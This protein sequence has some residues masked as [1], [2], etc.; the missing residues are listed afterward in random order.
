MRWSRAAV[1]VLVVL[2]GA[3][4]LAEPAATVAH[5]GDEAYVRVYASAG[6]LDAVPGLAARVVEAYDGFALLRLPRDDLALLR[7]RGFLAVPED[8]VFR[9]GLDGWTFD[10]RRG[11]PAVPADLRAPPAAS[12]DV[13]YFLVQFR[14][15][16]KAAWLAAVEARGVEVQRYVPH[17]AYLVRGTAAAVED[18][19][20]LPF[21]SWTGAYHPAYKLRPALARADGVV[22]AKVLLFPDESVKPLLALLAA[23]GLGKT[24]SWTGDDLG[25]LRITP[26]ADGTVAKVRV[27]AS[28]LRDVARLSGVEYVEPL[29]R[30][31]LANAEMQWVLQTNVPDLRRVWDMG[32][33]GRGQVVAVGDT[34]V[35]YDHNF[36]RESATVVQIGYP[37]TSSD[38]A[39]SIYNATDPARRKLIRYFPMSAVAAGVDPFD[40]TDPWAILDSPFAPAACTSGHGTLV[41]SVG[42]GNDDWRGAASSANDGIAKDA[43]LFLQ[44]IGSVV[45]SPE[46][47]LVGG[48]TDVLVY[49]PDDLADYFIIPYADP[50]AGARIHSNSWG[51]DS[52]AYT[53]EARTVDAFVWERPDFLVLFAN[54]NR[55]PGEGT[56][57]SPATSKS[58]VSV[59]WGQP[60]PNQESVDG[61]SSKGPTADGRLKP[62]IVAVGQGVSGRSDGRID[63]FSD[64][65]DDEVTWQGT[66]YATP[67]AA[68]VAA[69]LRQYFVE[70]WYPTGTPTPANGFVPSAALLKAALLAAGRQMTGTNARSSVDTWPNVAQG[71][72]RLTADDALYFLGDAGKLFVADETAGLT[73]GETLTYEIRVRQG[74]PL[75]VLLAWSDYPATVGAN[76]AL[77][78]DLDLLL[79][80]PSGATYKGNVFGTFAQGESLANVGVFD[81]RNPVE[82]VIVADPEPGVW[83][84]RVTAGNVPQGPQPF[85]LVAVGDRDL[86][87]GVVRLDRTVYGENATIGLRVEDVDALGVT[88]RVS[89]TTETAAELVPLTRAGGRGVWTG[90]IPTGVGVP[91]LDGV[92]QVRSGDE[93]VVGYVD[94]NPTRVASA[95][96]KVDFEGPTIANVRVTA[97]G[98]TSAVVRWTTDRPASS[99]VSFGTTTALGN[100]TTE[101]ELVTDHA[102]LLSGLS[103]DSLYYFDVAST[104]RSGR[105]VRD[106]RAG[107]HYTF[108]TASQGAVLLVV[109]DDSFPEERVGMYRAALAARGWTHDEWFVAA[110]GDP[111]LTTLR[112]YQAVLWQVGLEQYPPF[113]DPQIALLREYVD[114]GGRLFVSS[115][116]VAW[117]FCDT[118]SP[119]FSTARCG[120]LRGTLKATWQADPPSWSQ[121]VGYAG[122][123]ISG[124]YTGGVAYTPHRTGGA[125]DEIDPVAAGGTTNVTWRNTDGSPD[126]VAV[127]WIASAANVTPDGGLWNGTPSRVVSFFFEFTGIDFANRPD[128]AVRADILDRVLVFLSGRDKPQV[129]VLAPNG[130]EVETGDVVNVT[131]TVTAFGANVSSQS[132]YYSP[133]GGQTW[134]LLND[135]LGPAATSYPWNV[136]GVENGDAYLVRVVVADDG[137]PPFRGADRSNGTFALRRPG[138]DGRGPLVVPGSLRLTPTPTRNGD[139][140]SLEALVSDRGRGDGDVNGTI[141]AEFFVDAVAANGSGVP[142]ALASPAGPE[143]AVAWSDTLPLAPGWHTLYVHGQ[144]EDGNWGPFAALP[145]LALGDVGPPP[146]PPGNVSARLEGPG[147]KDVRVSWTA[148]PDDGAL[149]GYEILVAPTYNGSRLGYSPLATVPRGTTSYVHVDAGEGD[150]NAYFYVVVAVNGSGSAAPFDQAAKVVLPVAA[151]RQLL[152]LPVVPEDGSV[153]AVFAS[154][155]VAWI[156]RYDPS[157]PV[158]PWKA[159]VRAKG[160]GSLA[161]IPYA[162][163]LWVEVA[164]A[165][166]L[167]VAGRIPL[168][169]NLSLLPGWNLLA[170]PAFGGEVT[171]GDWYAMGMARLEGYD[172][173]A[174]PYYLGRLPEGRRLRVGEGFWVFSPRSLVVAVAA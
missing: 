119:F 63:V 117:A 12:D 39:T 158:D 148:S 15:P 91:R 132:L 139:V 80:A 85:A 78:N 53:F 14:G 122:D 43:K 101:D 89:S 79:T 100:A 104:G 129:D 167:V 11:E 135:T 169:A 69:L 156:R 112:A 50:N 66:S 125:G 72:G 131:W 161:T 56:V 45:F 27:P 47:G 37:W 88:V 22:E 114:G 60:A 150:T 2:L 25:V 118:Q 113:S 123:P 98:S 46:C 166:N 26:R 55:G 155:D 93:I 51:S 153:A 141:P 137:T 70:G 71:W 128:S 107:E 146:A 159:Y 151:G 1:V 165:G 109:G 173:Q 19:S 162:V 103:P 58:A 110:Q 152:G 7:G 13:A 52:A 115:H 95:K 28:V 84:I 147:R 168:A 133:D 96:A 171:A 92:L 67:A 90:S 35:D 34:G 48:D 116:D 21:V 86:G 77:V 65:Q 164:T 30:F 62:D 44:D 120:W 23:R 31:R 73:T 87:F 20:S 138:G 127:R 32:L 24:A 3:P 174:E 82:G 10:T 105:V 4:L 18:V 16:V 143:V 170:W 49:L 97:I 108:R 99:A 83:T 81:R 75:K 111:S 140:V 157:D 126:D 142:L 57:G 8:N 160:G 76:P 144:D 54:G 64:T 40:G 106:D 121:V 5:T 94:A 36:F 134:I 61:S 41:S 17:F 145:F 149:D 59:G 38:P 124:P 163:G 74:T 42:F 68:G 33:T 130:G 6:A 9:I 102:V 29:D 136:T 154:L 172:A